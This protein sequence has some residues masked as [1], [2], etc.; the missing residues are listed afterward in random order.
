MLKKRNAVCKNFVATLLGLESRPFFSDMPR[1]LIEIY[2][3]EKAF[4]FPHIYLVPELASNAC[5]FYVLAL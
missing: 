5:G 1:G 3:L 4:S 2:D